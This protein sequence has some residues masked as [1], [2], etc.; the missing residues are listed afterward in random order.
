M[1][2]S[3]FYFLILGLAIVTAGLF[4]VFTATEGAHLRLDGKILKVRVAALPGTEES[5]LVMVDFRVANPS[6]VRFIVGSAKVLLTP[7]TGAVVEGISISKPEIE[8]LFQ[9][10]KLL[11]PKYND[12]LSLQDHVEPHANL[13]R[14]MG[15]KFDLTDA[16]IAARKNLVVRLEDLDGTV[17]EIAEPGVKPAGKP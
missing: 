8:T 1:K 13:D 5:S 9:Y 16:E 15:V 14:M 10:Q 2:K 4:F 6:D 12:V 11:G 3:Y 7:A 17:A